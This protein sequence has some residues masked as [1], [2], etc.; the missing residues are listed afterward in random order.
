L[1]HATVQYWKLLGA[2]RGKDLD[3][4][5]AEERGSDVIAKYFCARCVVRAQ[6]LDVALENDERGVWGGTTERE[7]RRIKAQYIRPLVNDLARSSVGV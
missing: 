6:C 1:F 2:C 4:F 3:I 5:F 7:R